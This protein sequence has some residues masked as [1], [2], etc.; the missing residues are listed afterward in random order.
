MTGY[1]SERGLHP[2]DYIYPFVGW[3]TFVLLQKWLYFCMEQAETQLFPPIKHPKEIGLA[4]QG[5]RL[6]ENLIFARHTPMR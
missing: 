4:M 3:F 5:G 6:R 2:C 1:K